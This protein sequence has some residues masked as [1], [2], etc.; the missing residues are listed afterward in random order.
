MTEF[1]IIE[2]AVLEVI[3]KGIER[4]ITV[5]D[6]AYLIGI[7]VR[8]LFTVINNLRK[9]G[10]PI[11][12]QRSGKDRGFYIATTEEEKSLGL[13]SYK[14]QVKDMR[15]LIRAI[16]NTDVSNWREREKRA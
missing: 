1:N 4:K 6:L 2:K 5:R 15:K 11:C 10:V 7:D 16:E 12:A 8:S 9:K 14:A 3:P 13:A